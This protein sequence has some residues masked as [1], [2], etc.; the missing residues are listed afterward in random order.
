MGTVPLSEAR[1]TL[2][3]LVERVEQTHERVTLTLDGR[4][5]AVLV[6]AADLEALEETLAVLS[7]SGLMRQLAEAKDAID[8]GDVVDETG[9][10]DFQR[11]SGR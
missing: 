9:L 4:P 3:A 7:D 5:A 8:A 1:R 6:S 2:R 11:R 10:R